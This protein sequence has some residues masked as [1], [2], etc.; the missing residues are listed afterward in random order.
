LNAQF[1]RL[2]FAL[3]G[4]YEYPTPMR[5]IGSEPADCM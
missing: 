5:P 4:L 2:A 1:R 3:V